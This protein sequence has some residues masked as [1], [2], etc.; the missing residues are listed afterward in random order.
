MTLF[1]SKYG[2]YLGIALF[3]LGILFYVYQQGVS[4]GKASILE[5]A[6]KAG[7]VRQG[8]DQDVEATEPYQL[9][10]D[11]G[12]MPDKCSELRGVEETPK[13]Q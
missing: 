6:V 13:S 1:L 9:C 11:F 12:G 7:A 5:S 3:T 4:H 10:L 8:V 2:V